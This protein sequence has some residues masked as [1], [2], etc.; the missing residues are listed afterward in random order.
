V[1]VNFFDF[2][3]ANSLQSQLAQAIATDKIEYARSLISTSYAIMLRYVVPVLS[4]IVVGI[5]LSLNWPTLLNTGG[6]AD[7]SLAWAIALLGCFTTLQLTLKSVSAVLFAYQK[8]RFNELINFV[9]Q[10]LMVLL[11]A[12]LRFLPSRFID[13]F[14]AVVLINALIPVLVWCL[15]SLY[16]YK[17]MYPALSP[18]VRSVQW[19]QTRTLLH[20]GFHFTI[21][22]LYGIALFFTDNILIAYLFGAGSVTEYSIIMKYFSV[23]TLF[24]GMI[25][26]PYWSAVATTYAQNDTKGTIS[27]MRTVTGVFLLMMVGGGIQF[28]LKDYV[29]KLWTGLTITNYF[30]LALWI[31]IATLL[32]MFNNIYT[33]FLNSAG[34]LR[35][36]VFVALAVIILNPVLSILAVKVFQFKIEA[37]PIVN[38]LCL[39][40]Y[41]SVAIIQVVKL[42]QNRATGI[43]NK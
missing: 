13:P 20:T 4:L 6:A 36:Q 38:I 26:M 41:G 40:L 14:L 18:S 31:L 42:L 1:W 12:A 34:K 16:I 5:S 8:T 23:L 21:L 22:Q 17:R 7:P 9:I 33:I 10:A 19:D 27:L 15:V 32:A 43:W 2:G 24:F 35:L 28:L 29:I 3:L 11:V 25:L 37:I 39:L 30:Y